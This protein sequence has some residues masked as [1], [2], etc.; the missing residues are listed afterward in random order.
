MPAEVHQGSIGKRPRQEAEIQEI[1]RQ[2]LD[3]QSLGPEPVFDRREI[4]FRECAAG[5][6]RRC[7]HDIRAH[8]ARAFFARDLLQRRRDEERL[9]GGRHARVAGQDTFDERRTRSRQPDH[10]YRCPGAATAGLGPGTQPVGVAGFD[11]RVDET[12]VLCDV[13]A[14]HRC[15]GVTR[16]AV[17]GKRF[18]PL[19]QVFEFLAERVVQV[20]I[21]RRRQARLIQHGEHPVHVAPV[22][23][24]AEAREFV[25]IALM[26]G[27]ACK[28]ILVDCHGVLEAANVHAG[29]G[30]SCTQRVQSRLQLIGFPVRPPGSLGKSGVRKDRAREVEIV[31]AVDELRLHLA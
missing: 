23:G 20:D 14:R 16:F 19:A 24:S 25:M 15:R 3:E 31:R 26:P 12:D 7:L 1:F 29:G 8:G 5:S 22:P 28:Q 13:V 18:V 4:A 6:A 27:I 30:K 11:D 9:A 17:V 10:E 2:F 21:P